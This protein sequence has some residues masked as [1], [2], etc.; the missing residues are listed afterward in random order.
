MKIPKIHLTVLFLLVLF[1]IQETSGQK[2]HPQLSDST[3]SKRILKHTP[4]TMPLRAGDTV[5]LKPAAGTTVLLMKEP[6]A[7]DNMKYVFPIVTLVLGIF[8]NRLID[9]WS[10]RKRI[11][12][13]GRR[14]QA[15]LLLLET[16][17]Q[18]QMDSLNSLAEELK[19]DVYQIPEVS[20]YRTVKG[21]IFTS[22]DKSELLR[23]IEL[24][25][26]QNYREAV[27]RSNQVIGEIDIL[28][29]N[30][31]AMDE[32]LKSFLSETSKHT[33]RFM[34]HLQLLMVRFKEFGIWLHETRGIDPLTI[35]EF[36][37]INDLFDAH[38]RPKQESGDYDVYELKTFFFH[39]LIQKLLPFFNTEK[40]LELNHI[41]TNC[42]NEIHLIKAE[43]GYMAENAEILKQ[44]Y[45][46]QQPRIEAVAM[47][48]ARSTRWWQFG[49]WWNQCA[50]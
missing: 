11:K 20:T 42:L 40:G 22:L 17:I 33:T 46:E 28:Q 1:F 50:N 7:K 29:Y 41:A 34:E 8:L 18:Q 35:P 24:Y 12:R 19:K 43:K 3:A 45:K 10:G 23:Y 15:E 39:P 44:R 13:A 49:K 48:L 5:Q 4:D 31:D 16:P 21:E 27:R 26:T 30:Y 2:K 14:W 9:F 36:K 32:K 6:A 37:E 38:I 47:N 25:C